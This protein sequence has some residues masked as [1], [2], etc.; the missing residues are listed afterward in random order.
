MRTLILASQSPRRRELLESA[1]FTFNTLSVKVSE[2]IEKNL[3]LEDAL[4]RLAERKSE[5]ALEQYK[6][7]NSGEY[8]VLTADTVVV[9][10]SE[11]LGKPESP[12]QAVEF[13]NKLSSKT[14]RVMTAISL[15]DSKEGRTVSAV[16]TTKVEFRKLT[17]Q[18]IQHYV[19]SGD[20]MDKAGAYAI[21]GEARKFVKNLEG[22]LDNVVGLPVKLLLRLLSENGWLNELKR[23]S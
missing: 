6:Y 11:I 1:G 12:S 7:L 5:A 8:L 4:M 19:D 22:E 20:P 9:L 10:G 3:T 2:F 21:Q 18:E 16:D 23:R 14:H 17:D 15:F 13:L